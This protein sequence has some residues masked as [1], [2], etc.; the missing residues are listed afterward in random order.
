MKIVGRQFECRDEFSPM[1]GKPVQT[2]TSY[3]H[4]KAP[5]MAVELNRDEIN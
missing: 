2:P 3:F 5:A 1:G 4:N